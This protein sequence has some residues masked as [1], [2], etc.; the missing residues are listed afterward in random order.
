MK[1]FFHMQRN[2][3]ISLKKFDCILFTIEVHLFLCSSFSKKEMVSYEN[4]QKKEEQRT[5]KKEEQRTKKNLTV[6]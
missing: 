2:P 6:K 5:K 4:L 3:F 1:G